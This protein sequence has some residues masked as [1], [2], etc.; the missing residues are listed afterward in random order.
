MQYPCFVIKIGQILL[1]IAMFLPRCSSNDVPLRLRWILRT[2]AGLIAGTFVCLPLVT[3]WRTGYAQNFTEQEISNYAKAVMDMENM[4]RQAYAE[5]SDVM[6][7]QGLDVTRYSL[8]CVSADTLDLPRAVRRPVRILL[9]NYCNSAKKLV[10]DTGLTANQFN[11]ITATHE[12]DEG[13]VKQIQSEMARL[14]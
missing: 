1:G 8:S 6:M 12:Q 9:I 4:R 2:G 10:E 11:A 14:R 13:L 3:L 7:G 5:I